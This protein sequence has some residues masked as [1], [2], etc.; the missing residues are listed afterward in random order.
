MRLVHANAD[1]GHVALLG[2]LGGTLPADR[3]SALAFLKLGHSPHSSAGSGVWGAPR[4]RNEKPGAVSRAGLGHTPE[5]YL[6]IHESRFNVQNSEV[7]QKSQVAPR[8]VVFGIPRRNHTGHATPRPAQ[9]E[10][11][12]QGSRGQGA[13]RCRGGPW[14]A[15]ARICSSFRGWCGRRLRVRAWSGPLLMTR[16]RR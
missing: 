9:I 3:I 13:R 8:T 4:P 16:R 14:C 2:Q 15:D 1:G 5:G 7:A 12:G 11:Q 10:G 6:F